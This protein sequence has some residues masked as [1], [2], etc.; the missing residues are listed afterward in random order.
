MLFSQG[1]EQMLKKIDHISIAVPLEKL[2]EEIERYRDILG[3]TFHGTEVVAEQK[4]KVAFFEIQGVHFE[5]TA[6]TEPDS[7]VA[8]FL[9]KRGSGIHHIAFEVDNIES[10]ITDFTT[11]NIRMIDEQPKIGAGGAKIAF[12]HPKSFSG[13]L[14]ELKENDNEELKK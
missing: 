14:F 1:E 11:K 10:Q 4:V 7:P 6:P 9:D 8:K 5:L 12:A 2:D 3:L 13:V